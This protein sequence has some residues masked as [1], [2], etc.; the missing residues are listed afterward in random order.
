MVY[1]SEQNR[2]SSAFSGSDSFPM[3]HRNY[4]LNTVCSQPKPHAVLNRGGK[5]WFSYDTKIPDDLEFYFFPTIPDFAGISDIWQR[6][7]CPR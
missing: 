7:V 6:S 4:S 2:R 3:V 1:S 5:A